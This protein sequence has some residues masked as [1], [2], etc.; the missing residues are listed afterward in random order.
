MIFSQEIIIGK[1]RMDKVSRGGKKVEGYRKGI[2][3]EINT[4]RRESKTRG[5]WRAAY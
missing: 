5:S 3:K 2:G 4:N 1:G